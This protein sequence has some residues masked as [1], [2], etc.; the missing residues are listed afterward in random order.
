[1]PNS[2]L[3]RPDAGINSSE[4]ETK[5]NS[6]QT[7]PVRPAGV[8]SALPG[9]VRWRGF[10]DCVTSRKKR[11]VRFLGEPYARALCA[12]AYPSTPAARSEVQNKYFLR[13][14]ESCDARANARSATV[15]VNEGSI[16]FGVWCGRQESN[17]RPTDS[18]SVTLSS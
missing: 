5:T 14:R 8:A 12:W 16:Y 2:W 11:I 7:A 13:S 9:L 17:L 1:M 4:Y 18:K 10:G 15:S 3:A 6:S